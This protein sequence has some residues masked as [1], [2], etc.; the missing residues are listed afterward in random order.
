M[1]ILFADSDK[2]VIDCATQWVDSE[3]CRIHTAQSMEEL[4]EILGEV[5]PDIV[6]LGI[7]FDQPEAFGRLF[8]SLLEKKPDTAIVVASPDGEEHQ[9]RIINLLQEGAFFFLKKP[10][11]K[12]AFDGLMKKLE[13]RF[14]SRSKTVREGDSANQVEISFDSEEPSVLE[15]YEMAMKA[16]RTHASIFLLGPSGTGKTMLARHVHSQ[17]PRAEKPFVVIHCP[18][19]SGELLE[20]ELFGHVKGAFTGAHKDT[21][22]RIHQAD[23]GT[24]FLDE[25]TDLSAGIQAKL[26]RLLQN[27]EYERVGEAKTRKADVRIVAATNQDIDAAVENGEFREDLFYRLNVVNLRLP[28]LAERPLD[29]VPCA[30][31]FLKAFN[32]SYGTEKLLSSDYEDALVKHSWPGNFRELRNTIERSV[33]FSEGTRLEIDTLPDRIQDYSS[34]RPLQ[35]GQ[36]VSLAE[37]EEEHIRKTIQR[38]TSMK[39]A[40]ESL[41]ID[42]ATL[43][44]KRKKI[45]DSSTDT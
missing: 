42:T 33:I 15:V 35:A 32:R 38:E 23:G 9:S 27:G 36:P 44:R 20:S 5:Y 34:D 1:N 21:W 19:L 13:A 6:I 26:L 18:S 39:E 3:T 22:G 41:G 40:A 17:S 10:L 30:K 8:V 29:I 37:L 28:P 45:E 43:Y 12:K 7:D 16:A 25:I 24:L 2:A 11:Q 4:S 14:Q 31:R